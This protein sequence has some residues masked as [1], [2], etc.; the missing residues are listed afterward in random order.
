[1]MKYKESF[2]AF[3]EQARSLKPDIIY[4]GGDIVHNKTQG[5][6]P[7]L[8]DCLCWWF[9]SLSD[10]APIH[11]ILGNHDGLM[12]NSDRQD[13]ISP[14]VKA[15]DNSNIYL[16]KKSGIF[17]I[18]GHEKFNWCVFSCFDES[19][20][21]DVFPEDDKINIA[22]FHGAVWGSLTDIEWEID[23]DVDTSFFNDYDFALLG[24]IHKR[25]FFK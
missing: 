20:W 21:K 7:E 4:I 2:L 9:K 17:P 22:L 19:S 12:L 15:L 13:A 8:I 18:P 1:M 14:I 3:F 6:S 5:I 25:Q 24:D 16:Y 10:I 23:G 11:I